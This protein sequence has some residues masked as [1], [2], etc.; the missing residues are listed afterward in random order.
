M[1]KIVIFD[2]DGTLIDSKKDITISVNYVRKVNHNLPPLSEDFIVE[3]INKE[4]RNLPKL[5]YNTDI[6]EEK[7]RELFERH[8]KEQCIQNPY[9]YEGIKEMLQALHVKGVKLSVATN[10]PTQFARTMLEHLHVAEMFDVIIGADKVQA[11]KPHPDMIHKI[12]DFYHY[13]AQEDKAWMVGDNSKDIKSAQNAGIGA[14]FAAW[15]FSTHGTH[16]VIV[17]HPN[18]ILD[19]IL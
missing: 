10:A 15:G 2:M 11:S 3:S 5:F 7:D 17:K 18:E 8:Y 19:I 9:L 14:I 16:S 12:L 6:Y 13:D 4:V 1:Q